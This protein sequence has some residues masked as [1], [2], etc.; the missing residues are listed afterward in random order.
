MHPHRYANS[1]LSIA[2]VAIFM[3][4]TPSGDAQSI[5]TPHA[6]A[7]FADFHKKV[8]QYVQFQKAV[9]RLRTTKDPNE[10][11]NRRH[12]LAQKIQEL[13]INA[14]LG[15]IFT[16]EVATEFRRI[17]AKA[18]KGEKR[19][20]ILKTLKQGEFTQ[21]WK[22]SVNSEYPEGLPLTTMPPTLLRHLPELPK[23]LAYRFV[24]HDFVLQD[25][26]ARLIVDYIPNALP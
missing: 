22:L 25:T 4:Q 19:D 6:A 13:R 23:D 5:T 14:K 9:P 26:E 8:Q 1:L 3:L 21:D 12:A 16:L 11:E 15:D 18:L 2:L 24:G 7:S 20:K 17:I 10:I